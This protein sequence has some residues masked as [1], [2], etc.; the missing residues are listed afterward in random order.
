M[1]D[2]NIN[3][4][5]YNQQGERHGLW[6]L[7]WGDNALCSRTNYVNGKRCGFREA[8]ARWGKK[9]RKTYYAR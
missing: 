3:S 1:Q 9:I 2:E 8:K 6:I 7:Y 4:E 5:P